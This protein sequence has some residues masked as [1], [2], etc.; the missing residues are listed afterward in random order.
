MGRVPDLTVEIAGVVF[1]NPVLLASGTAGYGE[2]FEELIDLARIGG[3]SVKGTS[4]EAIEGNP[5]P[6]IFPTPSGMLNAIGLENVGVERF[7]SEKMPFLRKSNC[8]VIVNVF[9]FTMDDYVTVVRK[10]N[11]CVGIAAYELNISCPNTEKGGMVFGSSSEA[12]RELVGRV[13]AA[14]ARP[15][16]VKL[17]PNV[18]DIAEIAVAAEASG[19]DALTVA[20][21]YLAMAIDSESFEP[22]VRNVTA[23]LSGPAIRPITLRL[24]YQCAQAVKIPIFG[25]G[26]IESGADAVE[27]LLAGASAVQVGTASFRDPAGPIRIID[28]LTRFLNRKGLDSVRELVGKVKIS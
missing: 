27:Y 6:R 19:A 26:G 13:A 18:T 16:F 20:N 24:V 5:P 22:R 7:V 21:T 11:D 14:A 10:L 12:T 2:E 4:P 28:E 15:I 23:G 9:G 3:I 1:P 8:P 17:S 25:L